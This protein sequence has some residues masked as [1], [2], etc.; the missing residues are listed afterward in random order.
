[1]N[2]LAHAVLAGSQRQ[3]VAGSLMGDFVK[4]VLHPGDFP[5]DVLFG[6]RLH[7]RVDAFSNQNSALKRSAARLPDSLRRIAPPCIDILVDHFLATRALKEP[8]AWL[9]ALAPTASEAPLSLTSYESDLHH[10]VHEVR[11]WQ[12]PEAVRFFDHARTTHLFSSYADFARASKGIS[13]VCK[14]LGRPDAATEVVKAMADQRAALQTD[15]DHY[16]PE[17]M[18]EACRFLAESGSA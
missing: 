5:A 18:D 7:R 15:F 16:W 13:Y 14:R 2:F 9:P 8:K 11:D 1:M 12:S 4:G 3:V 17:L 10:I 6:I